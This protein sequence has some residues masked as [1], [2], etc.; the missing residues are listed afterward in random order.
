M[1]W[2]KN[3]NKINLKN[4]LKIK[5]I[6]LN[7]NFK[8]KMHFNTSKNGFKNKMNNELGAPG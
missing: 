8:N 4:N 2:I 6:N 3:K 1:K 7:T 5:W